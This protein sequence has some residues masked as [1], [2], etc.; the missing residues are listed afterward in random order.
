MSM[1]CPGCLKL[2]VA[3]TL[4][5]GF[6]W[7]APSFLGSQDSKVGSTAQQT[8]EKMDSLELVNAGQGPARCWTL[9]DSGPPRGWAAGLEPKQT[10]ES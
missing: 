2:L 7:T 10:Q 5:G 4:R 6:L 8:D 1:A 9:G 3:L